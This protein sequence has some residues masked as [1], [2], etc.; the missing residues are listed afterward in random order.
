MRRARSLSLDGSQM[1][2][3]AIVD[4]ESQVD[5][6]NPRGHPSWLKEPKQSG[7]AGR[8]AKRDGRTR[9]TGARLP[10]PCSV[11]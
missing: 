10:P 4:G 8:L 1:A 7:H 3:V 11:V 5:A 2:C 6:K 9:H